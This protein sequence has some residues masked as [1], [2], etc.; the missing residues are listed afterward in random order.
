[1]AKSPY[2]LTASDIANMQ[3][4]H[5]IHFINPEAERVNKS[6]GDHTG[7]TGLGV[8]I[9]EVPPGK[10]STEFHKHYFEDECIYVLEG[11]GSVEIGEEQFEINKG[12]FIAHPKDGPAH[13]M[14]NTSDATLTCIVMGERLDHDVGDYPR[15]GKRIYRNKGMEWDVTDIEGLQHPDAGKKK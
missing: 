14:V 10:A 3:G 12:D 15:M 13:R 9:V 1:M 6:L 8:H 11:T 5:K 2:I 7:L 4:L